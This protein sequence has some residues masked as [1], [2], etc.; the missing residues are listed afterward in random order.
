L[1]DWALELLK[2]PTAT[3]L[4]IPLLITFA[5]AAMKAISRKNG[6]WLWPLIFKRSTIKLEDRALGLDLLFAA[7]GSQLGFLAVYAAADSQA[8]RE[9]Q[10]LIN[11]VDWHV[12]QL[13]VALYTLALL[14]FWILALTLLLRFRGYA[15][16]QELLE[17]FGV[18]VPNAV[19]LGA[20]FVVYLLNPVAG[21]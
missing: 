12:Q 17:D 3:G 14:L 1:K 8:T 11:A 13:N 9:N 10:V 7:I 4:F 2:N 6:P 19:G 21:G 16:N 20:L 15:D 5:T 18:G